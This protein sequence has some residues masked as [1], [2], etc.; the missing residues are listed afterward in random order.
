[1]GLRLGARDGLV[2][3]EGEREVAVDA[4]LFGALRR[5]DAF[6][7]RRDLDEDAIALRARRLVH[8]DELVCLVDRLLRVVGESRV[9]L[10]RDPARNDLED[11]KTELDGES[12][13]RL[14]DDRGRV[15]R[16]ARFFAC[17]EERVV[18][19]LRVDRHRSRRRDERGIRRRIS[20]PELFD[21]VDVPGV[22]DDDRHALQLIEEVL[23]H[24]RGLRLR[25]H[26]RQ[27]RRPQ[28]RSRH[29]SPTRRGIE[30]CGPP[31]PPIGP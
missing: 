26:P 24:I 28:T 8:R 16:R 31:S 13:D 27:S 20:R 15:R 23:A 9:D 29:D 10:G 18:D 6:P 2:V 11:A 25:R 7:R 12:I 4:F 14:F 22:G 17:P 3:A 30:A 19:D 1:V 5:L 21:R